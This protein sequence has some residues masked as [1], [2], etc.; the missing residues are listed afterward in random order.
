MTAPLV[1]PELLDPVVAYFNPRQVILFRSRARGDAGPDSDIDLLV[2]VDDD[3]PPDKVTLRAGFESHQAYHE[4]A[5][6]FPVRESTF[7]RESRVAGTLSRAATLEGIVVYGTPSIPNRL[8][9][10]DP[11]DIWQEVFAWLR[12]ADA[13]RRAARVCMISDPPVHNAAA[14]HCHQAAEKPLKGLLVYASIDLGKT[15]DLGRLGRVVASHFPVV[16]P[17][18]TAIDDWTAWSV[19]YRYPD[20]A[21]PQPEP[22]AEELSQALDMIERLDTALRSLAPTD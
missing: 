18:V 10:P 17:L 6:V 11:A 3:T 12:V 21:E 4:P 5:D 14:F 16:A 20:L 22:S 8:N 2:I 13:G 19:A 1:P 9:I 7:Q 15:H